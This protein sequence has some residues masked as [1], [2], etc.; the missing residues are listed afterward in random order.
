MDPEIVAR[1][2]EFLVHRAGCADVQKAVNGARWEARLF[3]EQHDSQRSVVD[4]FYGPQAGSY[5]DE[6]DGDPEL[7]WQDYATRF[8]FL[9]CCDQLA[10]DKDNKP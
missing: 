2:S 8:K 10:Y 6:T 1:D 7:A 5:Y 3:H 9:P 4:R